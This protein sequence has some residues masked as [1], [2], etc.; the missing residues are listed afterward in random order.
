MKDIILDN[1][2]IRAHV[3]AY[4]AEL[5]S[6]VMDGLEYLWQ[7][8]PEYYDRTSPT[9]FPIMGRFLSDTYYVGD[10][11]YHMG[12]NGFAMHRN[13]TVEEITAESALFSLS[14]DERTRRQYPFAFRLQVRYTLDGSMMRVSYHLDNTGE[15]PLP[16]CFGCH[17]AYRWPLEGDDPDQ[18][19]LRFEK[20]ENV[21][22]FNPFN[23]RDPD[24]VRDGYRPLSHS[25]FSNYTRS[26]TGI[27][28]EYIEYGSRSA[29]HGVRIHRKE[30][31]YLAMWTLPD[32]NARLVCLEPSTSVHA[33]AATTIEDRSGTLV[34]AP[35]QSCDRKFAIELF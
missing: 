14:D 9:L 34:I 8:D 31:P 26:M 17:T 15:A 27:A 32:E 18:Y 11:A 28:S 22:S 13:F 6:L 29:A 10:Q 25:L 1:G 2:R 24:F 23:W 19:Y 35:G 33:G 30:F 5:K 16:F 3:N 12:I 21:A 20:Q 4:G 7:G